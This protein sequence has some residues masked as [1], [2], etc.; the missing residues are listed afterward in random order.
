MPKGPTPTREN[1]RHARWNQHQD[2]QSIDDVVE[3]QKKII[4]VEED[5]DR[6]KLD[7]QQLLR[8]KPYL[9]VCHPLRKRS[10]SHSHNSL[11]SNFLC[12]VW[13]RNLRCAWS[14]C[15]SVLLFPCHTTLRLSF[16]KN[17]QKPSAMG[18]TSDQKYGYPTRRSHHSPR[19]SCSE[20]TGMLR[21]PRN[22]Y[23]QKPIA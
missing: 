2:A 10:L 4:P 21:R 16:P 23:K 9:V 14:L 12:C 17:S 11:L 20:Q 19:F 7:A 1:D 13:P 15:L 22:R 5:Q 6:R 8:R 18:R 3:L